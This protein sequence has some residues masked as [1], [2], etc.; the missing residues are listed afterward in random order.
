MGTIERRVTIVTVF[1]FLLASPACALRPFVP[2]P[3]APLALRSTIVAADGTH[4]A[5]LFLQ[6][7]KAVPARAIPAVIKSATVAAEDARFLL[8]VHERGL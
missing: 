4:L 3:P 1:A 8:L 6:N 5:T 2:P 7:R